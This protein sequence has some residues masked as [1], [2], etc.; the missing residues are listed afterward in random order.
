M[1]F[2]VIPP[3]TNSSDELELAL[4]TFHESQTL[5][6][7]WGKIDRPCREFLFPQPFL[8]VEKRRRRS[9][10]QIDKLVSMREFT[11]ALDASPYRHILQ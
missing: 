11:Q 4:Q 7:G 6:R 8:S 5:F 10:A 1:A 9:R 3:V 2:I